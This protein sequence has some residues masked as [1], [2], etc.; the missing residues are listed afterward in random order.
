MKPRKPLLLGLAFLLAL[1]LCA[2]LSARAADSA[3]EVLSAIGVCKAVRAG[4][5]R[6]LSKGDAVNAED[7]LSTGKDARL[8]VKMR[9]GTVISLGGGT[10]YKITE[11]RESGDKPVFRSRLLH[12]LLRIVTGTLVTRNPDGFVLSAPEAEVGIRG[13]TLTLQVTGNKTDVYVEETKEQVFV[14]G[15]K[16]LAGFMMPA[17]GGTPRRFQK[18]DLDRIQESLAQTKADA[19]AASAASAKSGS[20]WFQEEINF[21]KVTCKNLVE[22]LDGKIISPLLGWLN[23]YFAAQG[24][25]FVWETFR[26][27]YPRRSN[28]PLL[29][30][31][32]E[33]PPFTEGKVR[34]EI[35]CKMYDISIAALDTKVRAGKPD[36]EIVFLFANYEGFVSGKMG[37]TKGRVFGDNATEW[38]RKNPQGTIRIS[39][40]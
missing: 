27:L 4:Q 1:S 33:F 34:I 21:T 12:G 15:I 29:S 3:G 35:S 31:V 20:E 7:A 2:P 28:T 9:D 23:G 32:S 39:A 13:T 11:Y 30:L 40:K 24:K 18:K 22:N 5:S 38:C 37:K 17:G 6:N 14:N 19:A 25:S 8:Q 16:V 36:D 26:R 10:T